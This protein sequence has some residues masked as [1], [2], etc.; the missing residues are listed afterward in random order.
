MIQALQDPKRYRG[1]VLTSVGLRKLQEG[2]QALE[3]KTGVRQGARAIAERVQT[4]EPNGIHPITVRK[5]LRGEQ[6]VDKR[7]IH[8]VF[9]A[10]QL[11][12]DIRDYAHASLRDSMISKCH[13][14]SETVC[15]YGYVPTKLESFE[16]PDFLGR[17]EERSL[18]RYHI[19]EKQCRLLTVVGAVG[20]GKTALVKKLM[21]EMGPSFEC[22]V[23][24]SL[25]H[26][27]TLAETLLGLLQSLQSLMEPLESE[28][29]LPI[30]V[31]GRMDYLL[32]LLQ[33][34]RCLLVL[35]GMEA[36]LGDRPLAGYY[37]EEHEQYGE[38]FR[39]IA[40]SCH[41]SCLILTSQE[42]LRG[43][44]RFV[45]GW[46]Q[47]VHLQGLNVS[48]SQRLLQKQGVFIDQPGDWQRLIDYYAGNPLLLKLVAAQIMDY[49]NGNLSAYLSEASQAQL[50]FQ[51]IRDLLAQQFNC[52]SPPEQ[53]VLTHL[54]M[55]GNWVALST[56]QTELNA[57]ISR[58]ELLDL[59]DSL[60]RRSLFQK[61]DA[62]FKLSNVMTDFI[63]TTKTIH[64]HRAEAIL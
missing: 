35:D 36:I 48:A 28:T 8:H 52:A 38:F 24:K 21:L 9:A 29:Q 62:T 15:L 42:K 2:I 18:L 16:E 6:G 56:L 13:N 17:V 20:M 61:S 4:I 50:L 60:Y 22:V 23:W 33:Q 1:F 39:A 51:D 34:H 46:V 43:F 54:A 7:S 3:R 64:C 63:R 55:A 30:T 12:L 41:L 31:E 53:V 32:S 19:L 5:L 58:Q 26:A 45:N 10:L 44:E 40:E 49:F 57:V 47:T 37:R 27:P 25:H 14:Q 11:A 59:L